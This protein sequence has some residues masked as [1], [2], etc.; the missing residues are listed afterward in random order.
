[1][2]V[3]ALAGNHPRKAIEGFNASRVDFKLGK[4]YSSK[5]Y[6][7]VEKEQST[8]YS[9]LLAIYLILLSRYSSELELII[10]VP[11]ANRNYKEVED[12]VGCFVN[13]LPIKFKI[14]G[15]ESFSNL[16]KRLNQHLLDAYNNQDAP[17]EEIVKEIHPN[18]DLSIQPLIQTMCVLHNTPPVEIT[19]EL[20]PPIVAFPV[21]WPPTNKPPVEISV[22]FRV[23][24]LKN[25]G[26][27]TIPVDKRSAFTVENV[28]DVAYT[29]EAVTVEIV[30]VRKVPAAATRVPVDK[31]I[32]LVASTVAAPP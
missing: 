29:L 3:L 22:A 8:L 1:M 2:P 7:F 32:V 31:F 14:N 27:R 18:R 30:T 12:L 26:A 25:P 17:I 19:I 15:D 11:I 6:K 28:A 4:D 10:G 13:T 23:C 21:P 24:A 9:F 16:L 20:R 5:I